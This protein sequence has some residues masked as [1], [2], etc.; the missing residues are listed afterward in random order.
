MTQINVHGVSEEIAKDLSDRIRECVRHLW[1]PSVVLTRDVIYSI[2]SEILNRS[3]FAGQPPEQDDL[4]KCFE[5]FTKPGMIVATNKKMSEAELKQ[6]VEE[7]VKQH[8]ANGLP[9]IHEPVQNGTIKLRPIETAPRDGRYILLFGDSGYVTTPLRCSVGRYV[10]DYRPK[11]PWQTHSNDA[12]TDDGGLPTHWAP[13]PEGVVEQPDIPK[14]L[15]GG[16][17]LAFTLSADPENRFALMKLLRSV[18]DAVA[19]GY[20]WGH[21]DTGKTPHQWRIANRIPH[22]DDNVFQYRLHATIDGVN[23]V[24]I[25]SALGDIRRSISGGMNAVATKTISYMYDYKIGR[26]DGKD[27]SRSVSINTET[28]K[29]EKIDLMATFLGVLNNAFK[30]DSNAIHSLFEFRVPCSANLN[31]KGRVSADLGPVIFGEFMYRTGVLHLINSI[32]FSLGAG[33][34]TP[35]YEMEASISSH[36]MTGFM[37]HVEP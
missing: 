22:G 20:E 13:L 29:D 32:L 11:N 3:T 8:S 34:I 2:V 6:Q 12:F 14:S 27:G 16:G 26:I 9:F 33:I 5:N 7:I 36:Q 23:L 28:P 18:M 24:G 15:L 35:R 17:P 37:E 19:D 4:R 10:P 25:E 1:N 31:D 21:G 30:A